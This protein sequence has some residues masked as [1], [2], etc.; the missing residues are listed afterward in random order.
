MQLKSI[1]VYI[2]SYVKVWIGRSITKQCLRKKNPNK[3]RPALSDYLKSSEGLLLLPKLRRRIL[4]SE[5]R[6]NEKDD[7]ILL[8]RN[9][10]KTAQKVCKFHLMFAFITNIC[11]RASCHTLH[12]CVLQHQTSLFLCFFIHCKIHDCIRYDQCARRMANNRSC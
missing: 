3:Q 9:N 7:F 2:K 1:K 12:E 6:G 4:W 11:L 10:G 5:T 8:K